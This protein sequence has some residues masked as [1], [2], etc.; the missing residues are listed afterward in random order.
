MPARDGDDRQSGRWGSHR[1]QRTSDACHSAGNPRP[2]PE[3]ARRA[4]AGRST[5]ARGW[6]TSTA[7]SSS[8]ARELGIKVKTFQ[9]NS[10]G[11][12]HH[13]DSGGARRARRAADKS[14][15]IYAYQRG[16]SRRDPRLE[17]PRRGPSVECVSARAV[18]PSLDHRGIVVGAHHG[19]RR[20]QGY[21]LALR[22]AKRMIEA[23]R[24]AT[25]A[26]RNACLRNAKRPGP[27]PLEHR[28]IFAEIKALLDLMHENG[29]SELEIEDKKGKV[30]LVR[31]ADSPARASAGPAAVS[32]ALSSCSA[33]KAPGVW[34]GPIRTRG[35]RQRRNIE[36]QPN[37]K[38]GRKPDGGDLLSRRLA[39]RRPF[40]EE[41]DRV[42]KGQPLCII[43]AMKMMNEIEAEIGGTRGQDT[44][45]EWPAG[46]VR[47][48]SDDLEGLT[49]YS[50][51][52]L[53]LADSEGRLQAA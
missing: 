50:Q 2:Q 40:V 25:S 23:E 26:T 30:R 39:R 4:R 31:A 18:S 53:R 27:Y 28:W 22:A 17:A 37:Q 32:G 14:R 10:E 16:D 41:G 8:S 52:S 1:R 35:L 7:N 21:R 20:A 46:R 6:R 15:G 49:N 38:L 42:R 44:G 45:G 13:A 43:E 11:D 29:L 36:L 34:A 48:A 9:S 12:D 33:T 24:V 19:I 5:D 47:A 51:S 3:S